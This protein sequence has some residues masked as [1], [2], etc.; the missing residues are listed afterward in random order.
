MYNGLQVKLNRRFHNG[1]AITT[2][3]TLSRGMSFQTGDDGNIWTYIDPRRSYARNDFDRHQTFVQSYVYDLPFGVGRRWMNHGLAAKIIGGWQLNGILTLM[4]GLPMTFTANGSVL[5][6]PGSPQTADQVA[7]VTK[8]YGV[9]TPSKGGSP[10]FS[11]S[12]FVQPTGVR[13]GTS[14]RNTLS[15]PNFFNA[16][17]SIFKIFNFTERVKLEI[18][19]E[20]FSFTNT[21]QFSR[22]NTDVSNAN[23]GYITGVEGGGRSMQLGAK[24]SF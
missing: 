18:R 7:E 6:T 11:Q 15:G 4:T 23:Y 22:P 13:F 14:G 19:G 20:A 16:D 10:W 1:L 9:N 2:S 24:I 5:N 17:A 8:L 3:Y 12:S 21:P